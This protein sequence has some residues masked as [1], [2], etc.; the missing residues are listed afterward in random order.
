[1]VGGS[2]GG[3]IMGVWVCGLFAVGHVVVFC[4]IAVASVPS[5]GC[6]ASESEV[7]DDGGRWSGVRGME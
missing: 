7:R 5:S 2:V 4:L 3:R 1:L 6:S